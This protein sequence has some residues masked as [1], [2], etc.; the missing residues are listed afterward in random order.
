MRAQD[1]K[2]LLLVIH[3]YCINRLVENGGFGRRCG[4]PSYNELGALVDVRL[5][6]L[7]VEILHVLELLE[8]RPDLRQECLEVL[9]RLVYSLYFVV[10]R[11]FC[12]LDGHLYLASV[13]HTISI[14]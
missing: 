13:D 3:L 14:F 7:L 11:D 5:P 12:P 9:R 1:L 4:L 6:L 10:E 2:E 8:V